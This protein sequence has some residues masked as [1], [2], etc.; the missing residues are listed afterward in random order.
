MVTRSEQIYGYD[1]DPYRPEETG[2]PVEIWVSGNGWTRPDDLPEVYITH[3][4]E[5]Q[6]GFS[7][8]ITHDPQ[9]LYG[10]VTIGDGEL[11]RVIDW[12]KNHTNVLLDYW[13][14]VTDTIDFDNVLMRERFGFY[15]LHHLRTGLP[16]MVYVMNSCEK[17]GSLP[18]I[19]ITHW[20]E[21][22]GGFSLSI[23]H[24]PQVIC[25][26]STIDSDRLNRVVEWIQIH[27]DIL[28]DYWY[29][30][31]T[32][33]HLTKVVSKNRGRGSCD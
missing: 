17:R 22:Q 28:L 24:D 18:Q 2:L 14:G 4:D 10:Q 13:N 7:L 23:T 30:V 32:L 26:T 9:V 16:E 33:D 29:G 31:S 5:N 21:N 19:Y 12:I 15:R 8:S 6:G 3:W 27:R 1:L 20:D 11:Y 25:G